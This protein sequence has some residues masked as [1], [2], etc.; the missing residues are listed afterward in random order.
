MP[1]YE[2]EC[3][4]CGTVF[5]A[6]QKITDDPLETCDT[7]NGRVNRLISQCSFQLKGSGWYVTDYKTGGAT[8]SGNGV[9]SAEGKSEETKVEK[10][11]A[12]PETKAEPQSGARTEAT[13]GT[14]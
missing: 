7:C 2:Y 3:S 13:G 4:A 5:E 8:S 10:T 11:E 14:A 9:K 12:K 6:F 1:I